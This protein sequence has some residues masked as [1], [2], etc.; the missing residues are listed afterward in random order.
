M[1]SIWHAKPSLLEV[2]RLMKNSLIEH[3][4]IEFSEIG[5]DFL[6]AKMPVAEKTMQPMG[7]LHGG[8]S[9]ALAETVANVGANLVVNLSQYL[10]VG[11]ELNINHLKTVRS[12]FVIATARPFH[13]GRT[14]QV[15][16][17]QIRNQQKELIAVG[18]LT[19]AVLETR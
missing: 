14:T 8:A 3:L 7:I 17:I 10:C 18:R 15:W 12:G 2:N 5:E 9:A 6:C 13:L 4:G 19:V 11:L 16:D 1:T